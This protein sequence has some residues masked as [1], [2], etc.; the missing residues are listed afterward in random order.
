MEYGKTC[1]N[2]NG[3]TAYLSSERCPS[4]HSKHKT[5]Q[6]YQATFP[7]Q[8]NNQLSLLDQFDSECDASVMQTM[9]QS[10]GL[11]M[12]AFENPQNML[13]YDDQETDIDAERDFTFDMTTWS[14][15]R[16]NVSAKKK[17]APMTQPGVM[18]FEQG[19]LGVGADPYF[20][21]TV[22]KL[23]QEMKEMTSFSL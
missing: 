19:L 10:P 5:L 3:K 15:K 11:H 23:L 2:F 7:M 22:D 20:P 17:A 16:E 21:N 9:F 12:Q 14:P 18:T 4:K 6:F 1:Q 8:T 13:V